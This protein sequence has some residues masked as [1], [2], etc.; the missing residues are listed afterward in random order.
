M[1]SRFTPGILRGVAEPLAAT[2]AGSIPPRVS[3][4]FLAAAGAVPFARNI[5]QVATAALAGSGEAR[6]GQA[7][8]LPPFFALI[9]AGW[10]PASTLEIRE[11]IA[12]V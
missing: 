9:A 4:T 8:F 7:R 5:G 3:P 6:L 1:G 12:A 2:L 11:T 10:T